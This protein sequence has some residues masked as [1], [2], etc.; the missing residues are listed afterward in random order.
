[1]NGNGVI[2]WALVSLYIETITIMKKSYCGFPV[3]ILL[4]A[5]MGLRDRLPWNG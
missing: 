3:V 5:L 2:F 1:M 4:N